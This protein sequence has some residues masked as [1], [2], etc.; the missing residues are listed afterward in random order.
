M[1][2]SLSQPS[3]SWLDRLPGNATWTEVGWIAAIVVVGFVYLFV[4][5]AI[6]T[7]GFA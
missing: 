3:L 1:T 7:G 4:E 6:R 2:P 5:L